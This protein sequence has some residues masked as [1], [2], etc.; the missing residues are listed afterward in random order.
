MT[1][2][3]DP[4][5]QLTTWIDEAASALGLEPQVP[6]QEILDVARDAAHGV[7]RPAAPVSTYLLGIAVARGADPAVASAVLVELARGWQESE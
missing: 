7:V 6:V 1:D 3:V 2:A 5:V 4:M